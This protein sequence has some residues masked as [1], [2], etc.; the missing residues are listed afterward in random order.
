MN[1]KMLATDLKKYLPNHKY[2]DKITSYSP[3]Y[4]RISRKGNRHSSFA[5]EVQKSN[6]QSQDG[7]SRYLPHTS[8][9]SAKN[10]KRQMYD[11]PVYLPGVSK[12][13]HPK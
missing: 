6:L 2:I 3:S 7:T 12:I 4:K 10:T 13:E 11:E 5:N 8:A 1:M 9:V